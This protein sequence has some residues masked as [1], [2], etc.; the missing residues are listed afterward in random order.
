[1][2]KGKVYT[3]TSRAIAVVGIGETVEQAEQ[4]AENALKFVQ[5]K[6]FVRH[7]IGK[8]ELIRKR[9]KHMAEIRGAV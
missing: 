2:E 6:V 7:D 9:V 3:T 8:M 4:K 1:E 5:G